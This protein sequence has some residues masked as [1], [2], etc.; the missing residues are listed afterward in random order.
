[1]YA[2]TNASSV[3]SNRTPSLFTSFLH[4]DINRRHYKER[5]NLFKRLS[6]SFSFYRG[7]ARLFMF[8][9][10][11]VQPRARPHLLWK[12]RCYNEMGGRR[13]SA[14]LLVRLTEPF[15]IFSPCSS[16]HWLSYLRVEFHLFLQFF[17]PPSPRSPGPFLSYLLWERTIPPV[18][19][20]IEQITFWV[21][22]SSRN[23]SHSR[24]FFSLFHA[25]V[26]VPSGIWMDID[27][28]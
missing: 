18:R 22:P 5:W 11:R 2:K 9:Q 24:P 23:S 26:P 27:H 14:L 17:I 12:W 25:H 13:G 28:Y 21:A 15:C 10:R 8:S 16:R 20:S 6:S 4:S 1:M 19:S 3:V 7:A